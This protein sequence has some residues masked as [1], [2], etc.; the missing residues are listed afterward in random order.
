V[1]IKYTIIF[2]SK[3]LQNLPKFGFF[4]LKT[5]HLATLRTTRVSWNN[6]TLSKKMIGGHRYLAYIWHRYEC[7]KYERMPKTST[8]ITRLRH[9]CNTTKSLC[10]FCCQFCLF[11]CTHG[12]F[13]NVLKCVFVHQFQVRGI[14]F[15]RHR[16]FWWEHGGIIWIITYGLVCVV[17]WKKSSSVKWK[18]KLR[19]GKNK[20][21]N[22]FRFVFK[23]FVR[24]T[25]QSMQT[26]LSWGVFRTIFCK[27]PVGKSSMSLFEVRIVGSSHVIHTEHSNLLCYEKLPDPTKLT[28]CC[29]KMLIA[30]YIHHYPIN[31][32]HF[33]PTTLA[34]KS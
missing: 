19:R 5:N 12:Q 8:E 26:A 34:K 7:M 33:N 28:R 22:Q 32:D 20:V 31:F 9:V 21:N 29:Q 24:W 23:H 4:C 27:V 15:S 2:H 3:T 11:L 25:L 6:L 13:A 10:S 18:K 1:S 16:L 14:R 30:Q 17:V